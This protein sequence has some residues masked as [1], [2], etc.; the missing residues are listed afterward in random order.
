MVQVARR[1]ESPALELRRFRAGPT[2]SSRLPWP[3][4]PLPSCMRACMASSSTC[5]RRGMVVVVDRRR[6][7]YRRATADGDGF[8]AES[9]GKKGGSAG[10]RKKGGGMAGGT[11]G[12]KAHIIGRKHFSP[13]GPDRPGGKIGKR[14]LR[15]VPRPGCWALSNDT[16]ACVTKTQESLVNRPSAKV[17]VPDR[18]P[19][20]LGQCVRKLR[21]Q[22]RAGRRHAAPYKSKKKKR[23]SQR[24]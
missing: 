9:E 8:R 1:L 16:N 2:S 22:R 14:T 20:L 19:S 15:Q 5:F 17:P 3:S 10:E 11:Q 12:I 24:R 4:L 7:G 21:R 18:L 13:G 6:C 23:T